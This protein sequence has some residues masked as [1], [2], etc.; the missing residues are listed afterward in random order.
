MMVI[1]KS[2]GK[3][4]T[5]FPRQ[6]SIPALKQAEKL[7]SREM[8]EGWM[9][10]DEGWMKYE[11]RMMKDDD[12]KLLRGFDYGQTNEQTFVILESL[13][14]LKIGLLPWPPSFCIFT[15]VLLNELSTIQFDSFE[16]SCCPFQ[17]EN[18]FEQ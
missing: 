10:N 17:T 4:V 6:W 18:S 13:S 7:K 9:K 2:L 5:T 11:W 16:F 3:I 14:R 12:F 1:G 15:A 8:K